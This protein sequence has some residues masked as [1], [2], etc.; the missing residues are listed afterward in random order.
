MERMLPV[1]SCYKMKVYLVL[2][3]S[4][5]VTRD[6]TVNDTSPDL[7]ETVLVFIRGDLGSIGVLMDDQCLTTIA[8]G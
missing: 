8:K 5:N 4:Y 6:L 3:Y 2:R 7:G 1:D